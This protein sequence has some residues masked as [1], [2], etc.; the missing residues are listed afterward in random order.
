MFAHHTLFKENVAC[1]LGEIYRLIIIRATGGHLFGVG[2]GGGVGEGMRGDKIVEKC[3]T[4]KGEGEKFSMLY[5]TVKASIAR[6]RLYK[7]T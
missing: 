6:A 5:Y 7:S 2:G 4:L 1:S 3:F